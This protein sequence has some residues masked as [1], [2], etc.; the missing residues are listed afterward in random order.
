MGLIPLFTPT[1]RGQCSPGSFMWMNCSIS[2]ASPHP[3]DLDIFGLILYSMLTF[4]ALMSMLVY[5]EECV[6][7]YKKVPARKK[8]VIIWVNGAA[9]VRTLTRSYC[10]IPD[11]NYLTFFFF[12]FKRDACVLGDRHHVLFGHVD[13][14]SHHVYRHDLSVVGFCSFL[15]PSHLPAGL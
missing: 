7:I 15:S 2:C 11:P 5:L 3:T 9:P 4:M 12:F 1:S 8:S 13:P 14:Q 10:S 6:Y